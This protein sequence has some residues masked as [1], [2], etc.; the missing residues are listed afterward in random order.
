MRYSMKSI[1]DFNLRALKMIK[2]ILFLL[3]AVTLL[4]AKLPAD[5]PGQEIDDNQYLEYILEQRDSTTEDTITISTQSPTGEEAEIAW[6]DSISQSWEAPSLS[7]QIADDTIP[8]H[9][10]MGAVFIPRMSS[11][12]SIEPEITIHER[13]SGNLVAS[14]QT[15]KKY[16]LLPGKYV[17]F[18]SSI[19]KISIY[20]NFT[21][22][23]ARLTPI[24]PDWCALKIEVINDNAKPIRG[25]YDI[26]KTG[27]L[28]P[29]GR[30]RGR[31]IN[32]AEELRVWLLPAG[33]YKIIGP[34]TSY[35]AVSN[36]LTV[37]VNRGEFINY[38]IV[39]DETTNKI[40]GGGII[41]ENTQSSISSNWNHSI[42]LGGS[43]D[44]G[45]LKNHK[46]DSTEKDLKFSMLLY[47][48][49]TYRRNKVDLNNLMKIDITLDLQENSKDEFTLQTTLDELRL[50]S[51]FTYKLFPRVGPYGRIEYTSGILPK[52][53]YRTGEDSH[54]FLTYDE[55]P[56]A[57]PERK[58]EKIISDS[59]LPIVDSLSEEKDIEPAFSPVNIQS[60]IGGNVQLLRNRFMNVR[61]LSGFGF[62]FERKWDE[63]KIYEDEDLILDT[64]STI[65]QNYI[66]EQNHTILER[67]DEERFE[68]GP[69]F[70]LNSN[71]SLGRSVTV[72]TEF[73]YFAPVKRFS[74]PDIT[75]T[76]LLS[77]HITGHVIL[78]YDYSFKLIQPEESDLQNEESRHR[79]LLR[80]SFSK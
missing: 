69:E 77:F 66:Y 45:F 54:Y 16:N 59:I 39:Q 50:N 68:F 75:I 62:T 64:A 11:K 27:P 15:G 42:N 55:I 52:R 21:I 37:R 19:P 47:D 25:E 57:D 9:L 32:L 44:I 35:N 51:I 5:L 8:V 43:I 61:L 34:G 60:G 74:T 29:I 40:L 7:Q 71:L 31:D 4:C 1:P 72:D 73:R 24:I 53:A 14:G 46:S 65:Y 6:L 36:F 79:I 49:L 17:V 28:T 12:N 13:E 3:F 23:E 48:R 38:S 2:I 18:I 56:Y 30:G 78:D 26:A 76:N 41:L 20:K 58:K 63:K 70:M 22:Q 67:I 10:G 80:F 33:T